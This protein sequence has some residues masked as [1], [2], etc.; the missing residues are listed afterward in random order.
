MIKILAQY[1]DALLQA[2]MLRR[3]CSIIGCFA[4]GPLSECSRAVVNEPN[5][6][7]AGNGGDHL[8]KGSAKDNR[9]SNG[10]ME[11]S[12]EQPARTQTTAGFAVA[13]ALIAGITIG[14]GIYVLIGTVAWP[15]PALMLHG[16]SWPR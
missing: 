16:H 4:I 3:P 15:T 7:A 14:A 8:D 13:R 9:G 5:S 2:F 1:T 6:R 12:T 11:R 10:P